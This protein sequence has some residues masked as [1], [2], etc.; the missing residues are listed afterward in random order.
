VRRLLAAVLAALG[1]CAGGLHSD[2]QPTQVYLLRTIALESPDP[3][4]RPAPSSSVRVGR[5]VAGPGLDSEHIVLVQAD[6]RMSHYVGS[7]WPASL[8]EVVEALTVETLRETGSWAT[9]EG[10]A[11]LFPS[12]YML[13]VAIRRFEADYTANPAAPE[14]HV[15]LDCTL[16]RRVGREIISS[17]TAEGSS[18]ATAN[19]LTEVVAAFEQAANKALHTVGERSS[20]ALSGAAGK[21]VAESQKVDSPVPSITR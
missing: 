9:V 21:A 7:R 4:S 16:G 18:L 17:F 12:E 8:P 11:S 15:T 10:S 1:G 20:A 19:R 2:A 14:V 6:H 13:Q 5:P 3:G